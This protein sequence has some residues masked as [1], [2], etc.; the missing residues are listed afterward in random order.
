MHQGSSR[1]LARPCAAR[2]ATLRRVCP[3]TPPAGPNASQAAASALSGAF[4][5]VWTTTPW[6]IPANLAVAVNGE[7]DY[8]VVEVQ[9]GGSQ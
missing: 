7:L 8:S 6:T 1:R 3:H 2:L 4:F 9:V 5:G